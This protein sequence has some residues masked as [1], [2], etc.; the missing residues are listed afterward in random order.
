M[1]YLSVAIGMS[2]A[3][4][5]IAIRPHKVGALPV[6]LVVLAIILGLY[7]G[8]VLAISR[9]RNWAR[10]FLTVMVLGGIVATT[11][12]PAQFFPKDAVEATV[13]VV[14]VI[15]QTIAIYLLFS[16][17]ARPWFKRR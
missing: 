8:L 16:T 3:L 12:N 5:T 6:L 15:M 10:I 2:N 17:L 11:L 4:Y 1:L 7:V 14:Q 9:G 13:W